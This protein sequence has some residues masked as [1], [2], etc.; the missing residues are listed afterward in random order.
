[1]TKLEEAGDSIK[2]IKVALDSLNERGFLGPYD[3]KFKI[4]KELYKWWMSPEREGFI[5]AIL[6]TKNIDKTTLN[7]ED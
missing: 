1:M 2:D 5:K 4:S 3:G 7:T 6:S